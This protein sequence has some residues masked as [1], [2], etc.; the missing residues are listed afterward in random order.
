M[1]K[2]R[3]I[4]HNKTVKAVSEKK[5]RGKS[6]EWMSQLALQIM[7]ASIKVLFY[8]VVISCLLLGVRFA[9]NFGYEIFVRQDSSETG[10]AY[11]V[12]L[13]EDTDIWELAR[14]LRQSDVIQD[15]YV[16]CTQYY[17]FGYEL[18]PGVHTIYSDMSSRAILERLS[19][20]V[21]EDGT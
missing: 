9:Y 17:F 2:N 20:G 19:E 7:G 16:F 12:K 13:T 11:E 21:E 18:E 8:A 15:E 10:Q 3:R 1:A 5:K 14:S 6:T 4:H